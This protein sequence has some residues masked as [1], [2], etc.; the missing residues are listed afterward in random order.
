[1][2][3]GLPP[4]EN[5]VSRPMAG[6][7]SGPT[8]LEGRFPCLPKPPFKAI[9]HAS[10]HPCTLNVELYICEDT[11]AFEFNEPHIT[12]I[13]MSLLEPHNDPQEAPQRLI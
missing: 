7:L 4:K 3:I 2:H 8:V 5:L 9:S 11:V 13:Y 12:Y 1:M 10:I 6:P